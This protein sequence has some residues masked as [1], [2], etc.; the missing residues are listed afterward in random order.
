MRYLRWN[1]AFNT[2]FRRDRSNSGQQILKYGTVL[3]LPVLS[4]WRRDWGRKRQILLFLLR[5]SKTV[6]QGAQ[7]SQVTF[8]PTQA[9][10]TWELGFI[11]VKCKMHTPFLFS[12]KYVSSYLLSK[13]LS[14][15]HHLLIQMEMTRLQCYFCSC[16]MRVINTFGWDIQRTNILFHCAKHDFY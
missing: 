15:Y 14:D 10:N 1:T 11:C 3:L 6:T 12:I 2:V 13:C 9:I 16:F 4:I 7:K 8:F 5:A